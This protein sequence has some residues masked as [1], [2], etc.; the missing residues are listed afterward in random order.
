MEFCGYDRPVHTTKKENKGKK[1]NEIIKKNKSAESA[2]GMDGQEHFIPDGGEPSNIQDQG[3]SVVSKSIN[4][5]TACY[6]GYIYLHC[7][8]AQTNMKKNKVQLFA[9]INVLLNRGKSR[10]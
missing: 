8:L 4:N 2:E 6:S 3:I 1:E 5:D 10:Y 7:E 9:T